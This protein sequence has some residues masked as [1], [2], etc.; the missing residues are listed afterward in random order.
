M[1][2]TPSMFL[3]G[4]RWEVVTPFRVRNTVVEAGVQFKVVY[5]RRRETHE[6]PITFTNLEQFPG[7]NISPASALKRFMDADVIVRSDKLADCKLVAKSETHFFEYY[8]QNIVTEALWSGG[9]DMPM[10]FRKCDV[11]DANYYVSEQN[12]FIGVT[13]ISRRYRFRDE[14]DYVPWRIMEYSP[15]E[16]ENPRYIEIKP[17]WFN[18]I[19]R[20]ANKN[21]SYKLS[22][23]GSS[24]DDME[25]K[26]KSFSNSIQH[27]M[28]SLHSIAILAFSWKLDEKAIYRFIAEHCEDRFIKRNDVYG[29]FDPTD[30]LTVKVALGEQI[31]IAEL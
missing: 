7:I 20:L 4:S 31:A 28:P 8:I 16:P 30:A 25:Q 13:K 23:Y 17:A 29:F 24:L 12:A 15:W 1:P 22:G 5:P 2:N 14:L 9:R 18:N 11:Q 26:I 10:S 21:L 3:K 19:I 27:T 6:I